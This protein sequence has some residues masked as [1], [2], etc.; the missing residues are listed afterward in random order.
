MTALR[1]GAWV[2]VAD[3][4]KALFLRNDGD[5]IDYNLTVVRIE[6]QENPPTREQG[7]GP[8]GRM[9]DTGPG[10]RSALAGTDWQA[11]GKQR[12]AA[13]LAQILYKQAHAGRYDSLVLIAAPAV[14]GDLRLHLHAEVQDRILIEIPKTLT[15]HQT[16]AIERI[17]RAALD[18]G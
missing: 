11:L 16:D 8:P 15:N 12:F 9:A 1:T 17:V 5:A 4:E 14:L 3:G 18:G 13:D 2:L 7:A 6:E 10:Q